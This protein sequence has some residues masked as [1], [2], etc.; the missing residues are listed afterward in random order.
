M[1][2]VIPIVCMLAIA[3]PA[4]CAQKERAWKVGRV[5]DSAMSQAT[6]VTGAFTNTS[7]SATTVGNSTATTTGSATMLG[8]TANFGSTTNT[9]GIATT[10]AHSTSTT[11]LQ[12]VTVQ[13]NE[14]VVVGDDYLYIIQDTRRK[15]GPLLATALANRKHGCRFIVGEDIKYSQEK[16][17]IW[18]IDPDGKEC[19][20]TILRQEKKAHQ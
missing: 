5:L 10:S 14:L 2:K 12:H 13:T 15:G 8:H 16:G 17:D 4:F 9:S 18:V 6:Y 19:K 3:S 11:M 20:E 1:N 7:G